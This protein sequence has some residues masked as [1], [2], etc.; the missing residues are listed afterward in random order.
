MPLNEGYLAQNV[1]R[2]AGMHLASMEKL[3][4]F[5]S[6][7]RPTM[8]AIVAHDPAQR[9][10]PKAETAIKIAEAFGVS[11]NALYQ[12]PL[13]C[14]RE[15]VEH[16]DEAPIAQFVEAPTVEMLKRVARERGVPVK[17][18]RLPRKRRGRK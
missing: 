6:V 7:S 5:V 2:L 17:I 13:D 15:A 11:L 16:F 9:S 10:L 12:E 3:A 4:Q 8:Q 18:H 14:L 1:R